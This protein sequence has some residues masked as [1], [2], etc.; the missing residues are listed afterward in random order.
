MILLSSPLPEAVVYINLH[1]SIDVFLLIDNPDV[2]PS[3]TQ[4]LVF[5]VDF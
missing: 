4:D 5:E 3:L 2:S 1:N